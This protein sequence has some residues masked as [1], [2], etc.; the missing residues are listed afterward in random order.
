MSRTAEAHA[1]SLAKQTTEAVPITEPPLSFESLGFGTPFVKSLQK[2]FPK[3]KTPTDTQA[4]LIPAI[5]G[6]QDILLKDVTG[7]GKCV[8]FYIFILEFVLNFSGSGRLG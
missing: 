5:L 1:D 7:S 2:A 4:K 6:T 8:V 3:V